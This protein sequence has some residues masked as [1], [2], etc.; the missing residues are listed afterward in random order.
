MASVEAYLHAKFHLDPSN[1]LATI[2]KRHIQTDN[3][4]TILLHNHDE[5]RSDIQDAKIAK[6]LPSAPHRTTYRAISSQ[7]RHVSTIEKNLLISNKSPPHVLTIWCA[8]AYR[9]PVYTARIYGCIFDTRTYGSYIRAVEQK[10]RPIIDTN[11]LRGTVGDVTQRHSLRATG[12]ICH[13][14]FFVQRIRPILV[15]GQVTIIFV[16]SVCLFVCLFVCLC[17]FSQPSLIRFRSN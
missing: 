1:R 17:S 13:R 9:S 12:S 15:H 16:V 8:T 3:D 14:F 10:P 4:K 11:I 2:H 6:N 5:C 7:L